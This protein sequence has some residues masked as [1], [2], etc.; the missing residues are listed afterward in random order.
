MILRA[1]KVQLDVNNKQQADAIFKD[2]FYQVLRTF[3]LEGL[4]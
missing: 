4:V 3:E 1:Y 2:M